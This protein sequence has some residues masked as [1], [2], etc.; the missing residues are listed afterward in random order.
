M[1]AYYKILDRDGENSSVVTPA[2]ELLV[3]GSVVV[4]G[5][6]VAVGL[7]YVK[8]SISADQ[9]F[10]LIDLDNQGGGGPYKHSGSGGVK[11]HWVHGHLIKSKQQAEWNVVLLVVLDIDGTDATLAALEFSSL[12]SEDTLKYES[13]ITQSVTPHVLDLTVSGS[14]LAFL[15]VG[16]IRTGV[17]EV[18]TSS[19][20]K[21]V[22]GNDVV[23]S[24]GDVLVLVKKGTGSGTAKF[25]YTLIYEVS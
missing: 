3:K 2:G 1:S 17:V 23:P 6:S 16:D 9:Y 18:N 8:S 14:S 5:S 21:D 10:L 11:F 13:S 15:T 22:A 20:L 12:H 4:G 7:D 25:H 24:V 19:T